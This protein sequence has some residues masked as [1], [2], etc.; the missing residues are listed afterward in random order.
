[1]KYNIKYMCLM[2]AALF[3]GACSSEEE[4]AA[5][6]TEPTGAGQTVGFVST[7]S[8]ELEILP[9]EDLDGNAAATR[10]SM[11]DGAFGTWSTTDKISIS[12]GTLIY[13]YL[14]VES[15]INGANCSFESKTSSSFA[16]DEECTFYAFYPADAVL[17]WNG[18]TLT[19]MIYTE[20]DYTEN[21]ENS[22]VMGPYMAAAATTTNGGSSASF[23]F[24]HVC[25]VIDVD[26][27]SI[28][29]ETVD[30][31]S[32]YA[33][34]QVSIAGKL[35][36]NASTKAAS[37]YTNDGTGYSY[38]TQS[39]MIRVS[40]IT[41]GATYA[42]FYV[43]PVAQTGGFTITVHTT[44]GN[45]YTKSSS[46]AVGTASVNSDY[47]ASVSG[48]SSGSACKPYYKKYNFGST[49]STNVRT[50]NWMAMIPGNIKFNHLSIPGT[51]D[52]ATSG[53]TSYTN[54]TICQ[55]Y[56]IAQQLEMGCRA[57]DLRP[58]TSTNNGDPYIYH[59]SYTTNV[60]LGEALSA[61]TTFLAA[62]PTETAFV[63][64]HEEN[65][66]S[67]S[68]DWSNYVWT[69]VNNY[70]S[71]IASYGW[72]GNLNPCRGKMVVIFR[73]AYTDGTN[74]G[75]LGCGK[76]GWGSSFAAKSILY[77]TSSSSSDSYNLWYQDEYEY[78]SSSYA[79]D[80]LSNL[81]TML[82]NYISANE[83]DATKLYVNNTNAIKG[84]SL[85]GNVIINTDLTTTAAAINSAVLGSTTFTGHTGRFGIMM[86]DF[87]FSSSYYGDQ[88][89][90]LI[91]EQNFKYVYTNRTRC[92]TSTASGTDTGVDVAADE[93]A[94]GTTV[95]IKQR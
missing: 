69:I 61:I 13:T 5:S 68:T 82:T 8:D 25:S 49:T 91:H 72:K 73:D 40:N 50:M 46:T 63:L 9:T 58:T 20:Q 60:T 53:C 67:H 93:Y 21:C 33:N 37:V 75:D 34:S 29:S 85:L 41:S 86:T 30:A 79:S 14:P 74:T 18:S 35:T 83:T 78:T 59:G 90:D 27:S 88:M 81:E 62:N 42:R 80:K 26:F 23:T 94:D 48:V 22:G 66:D 10:S 84:Y 39:E 16:L 31:V 57:F 4:V 1:M 15:S 24:G 3:V 54:Y 92:T 19:T 71:S 12:D 87:L 11:S 6:Q 45:Y 47:L 52:A 76:V 32:I 65:S 70:S 38:S 95:Y 43:L 77:G 2:A 44:A 28:T 36:Y 7:I 55:D 17:G 51:H 89:F 64:I 56:T